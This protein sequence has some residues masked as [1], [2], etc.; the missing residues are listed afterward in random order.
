MGEKKIV[1]ELKQ[2][3]KGLNEEV[4]ITKM[5]LFGSH[6]WGKPH[7]DSD[8]DLVVVSPQFR[9]IRSLDRGISFYKRWKLAYPVDFLCYTPEEFRRLKKK[10]ALL[11]KVDKEGIEIKAS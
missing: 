6:A 10:T 8:V 2:F 4:T 11:R 5:V 1:D 7:R 9:G 3:R